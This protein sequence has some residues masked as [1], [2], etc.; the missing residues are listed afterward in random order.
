MRGKLSFTVEPRKQ[1]R[2][3]PADA[4]KTRVAAVLSAAFQDHPRGCGEN[5]GTLTIAVD[6]TGSPPRM[7]GK[8]SCGRLTQHLTRITPAD[9]GKTRQQRKRRRPPQ[10][11]PRGCGENYT[12]A[13]R[14]AESTGSP[15][16]MRGKLPSTSSV[17][18]LSRITPA[19]AGKTCVNC[20][21][22]A[23]FQDH[24]RGCGENTATLNE[25]TG[26]PWITPA[27]AGKTR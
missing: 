21:L 23:N 9:A 11:H 6:V 27:D 24:P 4:G 18:F 13:K 14:Y 20:A 26:T 22:Q 12:F 5:R 10:D 7:R 1:Y 3:T 17:P 8:R 2:I 16:R 19:D 15:P 25:Q